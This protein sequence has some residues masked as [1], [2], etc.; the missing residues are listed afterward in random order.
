MSEA[1][2]SSWQMA[3]R[4][5]AFTAATAAVLATMMAL[6]RARI[7]AGERRAQLAALAALLPLD[8]YDNDPLADRAMILA[9]EGLGGDRPMPVYRVRKAGRPVAAVLGVTTPDGYAGAIDL[10]LGVDT[11]GR[12]IGVRIT[13]H[14]ET[15]G[16]GD[17]I[18]ADKS[19]WIGRFAGRSLADP[20]SERWAVRRDGG[21]FD[22]F[23]GATVTPRA[24]VGAVRRALQW[25]VANQKRVF[26]APAATD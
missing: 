25:F 9:P 2:R 7:E 5:A 20:P 24:V 11:T 3:L 16:L 19:D 14:H 12:V 18:E 1:L 10:L 6:T 22:Q 13:R 21:E 15:P 23:A 26:D 17:G 4:L 8:G